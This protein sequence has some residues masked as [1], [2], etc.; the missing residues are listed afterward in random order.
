[1]WVP[2]IWP[3]LKPPKATRAVATGALNM[4]GATQRPIEAICSLYGPQFTGN[5]LLGLPEAFLGPVKSAYGHHETQK[6][7]RKQ[8]K[9][10][11]GFQ[12]KQEVAF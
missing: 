10:V 5:A 3:N 9:S 6:G 2:Q 8:Q 4:T 11:S 1:M 12:Q 7:L